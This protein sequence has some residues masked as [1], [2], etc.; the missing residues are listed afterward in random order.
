M[1]QRLAVI[2]A[3][4]VVGVAGIGGAGIAAAQQNGPSGNGTMV[5]RLV[6]KFNLDKN[7][8]RAVMTEQHENREAE[9]LQSYTDR[10]QEAVDAGTITADQ[11]K[12]IEAKHNEVHEAR[13][14]EMEK[15]R[16]WADENDVDMRY[17][18]SRSDKMLENSNLNAEQLKLVEQK[19]AEVQASRENAQEEMKT[20]AVEN[21]INTSIL[22]GSGNGMNG[23]G[24]HG[25]GNG[26]GRGGRF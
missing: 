7:E 26:H 15:L 24:R 14:A 12:A 1:K 20:W 3:A 18:M 17:L 25:G 19:R 10:L 6:E 21:D 8:V 22:G 5:D 11:K 23:E 9:R 4:T 16:A 13:E 2:G